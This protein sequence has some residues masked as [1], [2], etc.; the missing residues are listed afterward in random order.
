MWEDDPDPTR[1]ATAMDPNLS[2]AQ[3]REMLAEISPDHPVS[4]D[5]PLVVG[6]LDCWMSNGGFLPDAWAASR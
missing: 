1:K 2:L 5:L 6:A 3:I 4:D